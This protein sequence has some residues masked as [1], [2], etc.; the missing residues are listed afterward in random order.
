MD[1]IFQQERCV[2]DRVPVRA[3]RPF[4]NNQVC[5]AVLRA[6]PPEFQIR[7]PKDLGLFDETEQLIAEHLMVRSMTNA[8][9][10]C[11]V[12]RVRNLL[13]GH[14][15]TYRGNLRIS[16]PTFTKEAGPNMIY[17]CLRAIH[18]ATQRA[19]WIHWDQRD[20]P[21]LD[22]EDTEEEEESP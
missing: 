18:R 21:D 15:G 7:D 11:S 14:A 13:S 19:L 20:G 1:L 6:L 22:L 3:N 5:L 17:I 2:I 16:V 10:Y 4:D 9:W 8:G 12:E